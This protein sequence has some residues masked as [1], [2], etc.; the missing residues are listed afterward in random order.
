MRRRF[1]EELFC[2]GDVFCGRHLL[3]RLSWSK[4]FVE[5]TFC[6]GTFCAET[7]CRGGVLCGRRFLWE[8][9]VEETSLS[10]RFGEETFC[11]YI[12]AET[13]CRGDVLFVR[14]KNGMCTLE[15]HRKNVFLSLLIYSPKP[16]LNNM[17][18]VNKKKNNKNIHFIECFFLE[19]VTCVYFFPSYCTVLYI[20]LDTRFVWI[21]NIRV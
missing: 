17:L 4:R 10:K 11:W 5:E 12:C 1:V 6:W 7:F 3:R 9:F 20:M 18:T 16:S 14:P 19:K 2:A 8:T 15:K 13:F 21:C